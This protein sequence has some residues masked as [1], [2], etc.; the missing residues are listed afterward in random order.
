MIQSRPDGLKQHHWWGWSH[1]K[2]SMVLTK[3]RPRMPVAL[4]AGNR[5]PG[6]QHAPGKWIVDAFLCAHLAC[7]CCG[8]L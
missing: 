6:Q 3:E 4:Q 5:D 8:T 1:R 7:L 2:G